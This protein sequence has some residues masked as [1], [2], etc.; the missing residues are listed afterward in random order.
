MDFELPPA[1]DPRRLAVRGWLAGH[2]RP[3]GRELAEAGYVAPHWP[4][5]WGVDADP[6]HQLLIDDELAVAHVTRPQ[7]P[8]GIGWAGPTI[9]HAGSDEQKARYLFPLLAGE[10]V[11]CQLF[12]EPG[13]GSDLA[14]LGTRA[15]RDGDEWVVNGQKIWTSGAQH[16]QFGILIARTDA[17]VPK[18]QGISYFICPMASPGIEIRPITEMTGGQ[19]FNEVFLS[20]V[21]LP[22]A[23]LVGEVNRG[24]ALAKITLG[25]E[26][27]SL[28][29]GGALWGSGPTANDLLDLVR[30]RG[31]IDDPILRQ[32][33][34]RLYIEGEVLR[35]IR[36]RTLT[37]R[38]KGEQPGPE[39]SI[40]KVL[41]DE[42]GQHIMGLA[43]DLMGA[44][45]LLTGTGE[46]GNAFFGAGVSDIWHYGFLFSPALTIGGGTGE[47]QRNIIGERSLGLPHD[48]DVEKGRSWAETRSA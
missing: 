28:S 12:S 17:N 3:T 32:R 2:P 14:N 34:A 47:V 37:S 15:V 11:W 18:H 42:H 26:R 25:N 10:E 35:L 8:I 36:L 24:W 16:S 21:R 4:R 20:D 40:R 43:K 29:G 7:N 9:V 41:A 23:N 44:S 45:G 33:A 22:A 48:I 13:S 5:P 19:T 46:A 1:D 38:L 27:V 31:G 6:I 30:A 39:A